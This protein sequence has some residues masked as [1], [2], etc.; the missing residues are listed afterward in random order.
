MN[1]AGE[2]TSSEQKNKPGDKI[3]RR[4]CGTSYLIYTGNSFRV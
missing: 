3:T 2:Y 1:S 4:A